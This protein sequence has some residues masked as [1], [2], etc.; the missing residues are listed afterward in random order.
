M[1]GMVDKR[2][3]KRRHL[4]YY[5]RVFDRNKGV[6]IGH[7]IDVTMGGI[8]LISE[9]PIKVGE[10]YQLRMTLPSEMLGQKYLDIEGKSV[11]CAQDINPDFYNTGFEVISTTGLQMQIVDH[12]ISQYGFRD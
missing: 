9:E 11:W 5:L 7:L 8:M 1:V 2:N 4:I 10:L 12:L 6:F 3:L